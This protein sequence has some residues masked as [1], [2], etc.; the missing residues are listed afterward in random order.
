MRVLGIFWVFFFDIEDFEFYF[1]RGERSG[2]RR[3]GGVVF[4]CGFV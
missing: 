3:E 2:E 4:F 1:M